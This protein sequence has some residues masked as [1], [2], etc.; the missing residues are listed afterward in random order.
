MGRAKG[1]KMTPEQRA[2]ISAGRKAFWA[3][4]RGLAVA[5]AAAGGT[6]TLGLD[7][8]LD[9]VEA[10]IGELTALRQTLLRARELCRT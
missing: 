6:E 10:K 9:E 7:A 1:W 3:K 4:K 8:A 2:R 5:G